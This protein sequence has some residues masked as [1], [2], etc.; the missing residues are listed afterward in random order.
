M[1]CNN[2][3]ATSSAGDAVNTWVNTYEQKG[4]KTG[5]GGLSSET[6]RSQIVVLKYWADRDPGVLT[7]TQ[8]SAF[9][10]SLYAIDAEISK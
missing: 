3:S 10:N 5:L 1:N 4:L 6:V 7:A 8:R 9:I 2:S